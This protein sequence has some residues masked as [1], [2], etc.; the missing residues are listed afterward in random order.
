MKTSNRDIEHKPRYVVVV[1][2]ARHGADV[3]VELRRVRNGP[4]SIGY[5]IGG[6]EYVQRQ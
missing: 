3:S 4:I 1:D 5:S 6:Y 2:L